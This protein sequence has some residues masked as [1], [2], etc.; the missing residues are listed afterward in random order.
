MFSDARPLGPEVVAAYD[1]PFPDESYKA[2]ARQFPLLVP[3]RAD[4][5][6]SPPNRAAW[7]RLRRYTRPFLAAFGDSDPI[8]RG[9]DRVLQSEIPGASGQPHT[10]IARAGHFIRED[11]GP[12]LAAI[13]A[14]FIAS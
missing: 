1:A 11:A 7:E 8:T 4:D 9:A 3:T 5:P 10:T 14:A 6:A 13:V 12:E 2:G